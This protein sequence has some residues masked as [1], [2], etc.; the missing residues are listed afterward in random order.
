MTRV[1]Y[2]ERD[3]LP[4]EADLEKTFLELAEQWRNETGMQ[5]S[6]TKKLK[7]PAYQ[8][9]I[10]MGSPVL[11]LIL[12]AL[13]QKRDHWFMALGEITGEEPVGSED[14]FD[15]AI[16]AWLQWGRDKRLI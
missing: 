12:R 1:D 2:P 8:K 16:E 15:Q 14:N 4:K 3:L 7:H 5:S 13:E 11:P 6:P 10:S 9:I